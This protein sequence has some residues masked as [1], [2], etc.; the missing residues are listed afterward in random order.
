ERGSKLSLEPGWRS[1]VRAV[2]APYRNRANLHPVSGCL[3][4]ISKTSGK[5]GK[6]QGRRR[7]FENYPP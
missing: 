5:P 1:M 3:T 7:T 2:L 6:N 4:M